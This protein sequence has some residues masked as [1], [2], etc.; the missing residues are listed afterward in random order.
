MHKET[1]I[2]ALYTMHVGDHFL[3]ALINGDYSGLTATE[4]AQLNEYTDSRKGLGTVYEPHREEHDFRCCDISGLS[5]LCTTV[6]VS[7]Y[8]PVTSNT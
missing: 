1:V 2:K 4:T 5:G 8:V 7:G 6:T 3:P